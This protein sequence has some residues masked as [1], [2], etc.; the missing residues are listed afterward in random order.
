MNQS[1]IEGPWTIAVLS[2]V[3][4]LLRPAN[5]IP[6]IVEMSMSPPDPL[7]LY[8]LCCLLK[9]VL[10]IDTINVGALG[11]VCLFFNY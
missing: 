10:N 7:F 2:A 3:L 6:R 9:S 1:H 4:A 11:G 5:L 8:I